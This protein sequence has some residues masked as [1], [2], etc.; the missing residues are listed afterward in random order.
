[1]TKK[2]RRLGRNQDGKASELP[3]GI[4]CVCLCTEEDACEEGCGWVDRRRT[5]CT[6]CVELS[7]EQRVEKRRDSL[8]LLV[9]EMGDLLLRLKWLGERCA[10]AAEFPFAEAVARQSKPNKSRLARANEPRA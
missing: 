2:S 8:E 3:A 10:V 9:A 6:A 5:L 7:D 1:M 4:C